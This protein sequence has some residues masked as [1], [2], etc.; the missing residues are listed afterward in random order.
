MLDAGGMNCLMVKRCSKSSTMM[1]L[2]P[3]GRLLD[4]KMDRVANEGGARLAAD[5]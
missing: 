3:A 2:Q 4:V 5:A 1:A